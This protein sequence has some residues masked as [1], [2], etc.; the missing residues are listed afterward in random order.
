MT[1]DL[2]KILARQD[3][4]KLTKSLREKCDQL[5]SV[6]SDKMVV[7]E[8][9]GRKG[10]ITVNN[11]RIFCIKGFLFVR[12]PEKDQDCGLYCGYSEYRQIISVENYVEN[13]DDDINNRHFVFYPC[14]NKHALSFL[15]NAVAI[16]E[17]LGEIEQEKVDN[18]EKALESAKNI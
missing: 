13:V 10:G 5:E 8:L 18:I 9:D 16:I 3:Y 12:T 15:N 14:S 4:V 11:M 1:I 7:L 2:N 17:K 6:I